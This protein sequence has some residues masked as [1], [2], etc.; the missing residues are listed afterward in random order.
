GDLRLV[1]LAELRLSIGEVGRDLGP[2]PAADRE[3]QPHGESGR[4]S[5]RAPHQPRLPSP[6][7]MTSVRLLAGIATGSRAENP[8]AAASACTSRSSRT[9]QLGSRDL[10]LR[11]KARLLSVASPS[12]K[13]GP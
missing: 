8:C 9:P 7:S 12:T 5:R 11:S 2:G 13:Y 1:Q 6:R 4:A 10:K 3:P